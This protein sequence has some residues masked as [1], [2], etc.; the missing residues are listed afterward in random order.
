MPRSGRS[1]LRRLRGR[2]RGGAAPPRPV[3]RA[4]R[5]FRA[6]GWRGRLARWPAAFRD[7]DPRRGRRRKP[8]P[9]DRVG[10][11]PVRPMAGRSWPGTGPGGGQGGRHGPWPDR[12][13]GRRPRSGRLAR[14]AP[15]R[16][17]DDGPDA[18]RAAGRLPGGRP[19]LGPDQLRAR[20]PGRANYAPFLATCARRLR[21]AGGVRI[22]HAL[23]PGPSVG[24]PGR[25][26]ASQGA[27][28]RYPIDDMLA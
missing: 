14:L 23:G 5:A 12:R 11:L 21:H 10:F 7:V 19:R 26:P 22:D 13:S 1:P 16:R 3:R 25:R 6:D 27:Y 8:R 17:A 15:A 20:H 28:L 24:D 4:R 18:R 2:R 9:G